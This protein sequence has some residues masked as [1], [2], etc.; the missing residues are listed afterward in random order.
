MNLK[1]DNLDGQR[2]DALIVQNEVRWNDMCFDEL[3]DEYLETYNSAIA[4]H[5]TNYFYYEFEQAESDRRIEE[6]GLRVCEDERQN[7]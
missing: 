7:I 4:D 3:Y 1:N 2:Q 5:L 6:E